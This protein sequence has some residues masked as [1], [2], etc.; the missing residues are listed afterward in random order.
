VSAADDWTVHVWH[1]LAQVTLDDPRL[2]TVTSYC[3]PVA[4]R[5]AL[6]GVSEEMARRDLQ[7]CLKRVDQARR[8]AT[9][10]PHR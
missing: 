7:R 9:P 6:L 10:E 3:M 8:A 5:V 2:W 1:D 4:R